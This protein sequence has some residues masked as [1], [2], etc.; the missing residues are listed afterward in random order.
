MAFTVAALFLVCTACSGSL[1][2]SSTCASGPFSCAATQ[3]CW[4]SDSKGG[5]SCIEAK[6]YKK[7]GDDCELVP[8]RA[9]CGPGLICA[10]R[11]G[12]DAGFFVNF[13][14]AYCD[15]LDTAK[16]G[17]LAGEVCQRVELF[18]GEARTRVDLCTAIVGDG[19]ARPDLSPL[20][21]LPTPIGID[22]A[23][24]PLVDMA[25]APLPDLAMTPDLAVAD[26][27]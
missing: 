4:P 20:P 5:F 26:D 11:P 13:C 24:Q 8:G 17:C 2:P 6:A 23:K 21:D 10:A 27:M 16:H 22:M 25:V 19:G 9:G 7:R 18:D 3:A 15:P 1:N 12:G 14:T